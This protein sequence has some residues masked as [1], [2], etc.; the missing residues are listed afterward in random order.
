VVLRRR[1]DRQI[2]SCL[3][4]FVLLLNCFVCVSVTRRVLDSLFSLAG[5]ATKPTISVLSFARNWWLPRSN[6]SSSFPTLSSAATSSQRVTCAWLCFVC[7]LFFFCL[8]IDLAGDFPLARG[9]LGGL[10]LYPPKLHVLMSKR[11]YSEVLLYLEEPDSD[12]DF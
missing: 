4:C 3:F 5:A 7:V 9:S 11:P 10:L 1:H 12:E 2:V 8:S 6:I